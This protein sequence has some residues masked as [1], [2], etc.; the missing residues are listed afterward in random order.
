MESSKAQLHAPLLSH[1][2]VRAP[3]PQPFP[4]EGS[5]W[6]PGPTSS[7]VEWLGEPQGPAP[8]GTGSRGPGGGL[9]GPG[10]TWLVARAIGLLPSHLGLEVGRVGTF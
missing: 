9:Q 2:Q 8:E 10:P 1:L 5:L 7:Q 4:A 6:A 3:E